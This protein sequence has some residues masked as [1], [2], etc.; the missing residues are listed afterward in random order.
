MIDLL[1]SILGLPARAADAGWM[2]RAA[3]DDYWYQP[4]GV[5]S[6][7]GLTVDEDAALT[8]S[9]VFA[10]VAKIAKTIATLPFGVFEWLDED[11]R[12]PARD[13]ALYGLLHTAPNDDMTAVS[14]WEALLANVLLW[15]TAYAERIFD[16]RGQLVALEPILSREIT[17]SFRDRDGRLFYEQC[18]S[19]SPKRVLPA[20]RILKINGLSLNGRT[21]LSVIGY[22]REA[23][24]MGMATAKFGGKFFKNGAIFRGV[25]KTQK[26]LSQ[27]AYDRLRLS[28]QENYGGLDNVGRTPLLEEGTD[29]QSIGMP[30]KDAQLLDEKKFSRTEICGIFDVPPHKIGDLERATF[31]NVEEQNIGWVVDCIGPW[32]VRIAASVN[33][34]LFRNDP[35]YFAEHVLLGLLRG[36]VQRR[37]DAY[38]K[39]RQWGWL[40]INDVRKLENMNPVENG[41]EYL[42][43]LNMRDAS[44]PAPATASDPAPAAREADRPR[45]APVPVPDS[46]PPPPRADR[47]VAMRP[48]FLD[49]WTRIVTKECRAVEN[50]WQKHAKK[51]THATFL[52]QVDVFYAEHRPYTEQT[53]HPGLQVAGVLLGDPP[54]AAAGA[55]HL[56]AKNYVL[57]SV[58]AVRECLEQDPARLPAELESWAATK[59][60]EQTELLCAELSAE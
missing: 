10:C 7:T 31:S 26:A 48:I 40:S 43:P 46:A 14:F 9:A 12:R 54:A 47:L 4:R 24:G 19:G 27:Q 37:F 44:A 59:A 18:A 52:D 41:D 16:N 34:Q 3:T 51:G 35:R 6:S 30:L 42:V 49:A 28:F 39:G 11:A 13:H 23:V 17:N 25:I 32:C 33:H 2:S 45:E 56:A 55:A 20:D 36:D 60:A 15:G 29:Y 57:M 21:G 53:L 58:A 38:T 1:G 50:L 5:E 8:Y 22:Q